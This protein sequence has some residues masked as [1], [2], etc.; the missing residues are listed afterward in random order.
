MYAVYDYDPD[1]VEVVETDI[2]KFLRRE[3][4]MPHLVTYHS[5]FNG[6]WVLALKEGLKMVDIGYL[7]D[8][9]G[10]AD[11][12][13]W[14]CKAQSDYLVD[15]LLNLITIAEA[16]KRLKTHQKGQWESVTYWEEQIKES[17]RRCVSSVKRRHGELQAEKVLRAAKADPTI[18]SIVSDGI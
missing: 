16:R 11:E 13:P 6:S 4:K 2:A 9:T 5:R 3:T 7:G 12:K 1:I 8:G 15:R 17:I 14:I 18:G 10:E